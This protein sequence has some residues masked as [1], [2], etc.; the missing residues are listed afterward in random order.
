MNIK[1]IELYK[2]KNIYSMD[3]FYNKYL[4]ESNKNKKRSSCMKILIICSKKFYNR[5]SNIKNE[6]EKTI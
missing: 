1:N 3:E 2:K 6:L 5:I 4:E